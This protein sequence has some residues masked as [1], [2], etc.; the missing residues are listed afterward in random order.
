MSRFIS[1]G[2]LGMGV[3]ALLAAPPVRA[4]TK[5]PQVP[6]YDA[7]LRPRVVYVAGSTAARPFLGVLA[8]LLA[9]ESPPVTVVYQAQGSCNGVEAIYSTDA[10]K[11]VIK[12]IPEVGA[13]PANYAIFFEA[14][15]TTT[16]ECSLDTGG[17]QV[18][19]G[20]SDVYAESC[21]FGGAG[22]PEVTEYLGP[23][24]PMVWVVPAASSQQ[25]ISAEAAYLA[26]GLGGNQG[27]S[28]PWVDPRFYFVRNSKSGTQQL[29]ARA[30]G[31]A[32]NKWWGIDRGGSSQIV[33][34]MKLL[35]DQANAE[36]SLAILST[37]IADGE[38]SNLRILAFQAKDQRCGYWP[39]SAASSFDK[40][41]VRE[42][43]YAM[44]GP[45]HFFARTSGGVPNETTGALVSRFSAQRL[46]TELIDAVIA[47]HLVPLCAMKVT[48]KSEMGPL[49]RF[50]PQFQCGCYFEF[51]ADGATGCK[52]CKGPGDCPSERPACNYGYCETQ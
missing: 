2:A 34:A 39:D 8:K 9:A 49:E 25:S 43:R 40:L 41:N 50:T 30:I 14:D 6:C 26:V 17:N 28:A 51:A 46:E 4:Q 7:G 11:R 52:A 29:I 10:Q 18:D 38:R 27:A 47:R 44:W 31:V 23:V 33:A 13:T 36:K 24:Q 12:D 45:L 21:G 3:A 22:G 35:V 48:R 42:G 19:V 5:V 16:R 1:L 15:G 20:L 37:D 32:A